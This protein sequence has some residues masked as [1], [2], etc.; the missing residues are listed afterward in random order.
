MK[1]GASAA[2]AA[3]TLGGLAFA[4]DAHANPERYL[5]EVFLMGTSFCPEGSLPADGQMMTILQYQSLYS[6]LGTTYGGDGRVSF[7]LPDLRGRAPIHEGEGPGLN[8]TPLGARGGADT[9]TL[10]EANLPLHSHDV[11]ASSLEA[12]SGAPTNGTFGTSPNADV[13]SRGDEAGMTTLSKNVIG[14]TGQNR[15]FNIRGPYLAMQYCIAVQ[16]YFPPRP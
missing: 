16:G 9:Q 15:P 13:Y 3:L 10:A 8:P 1:I 12:T 5:G 7:A 14:A 2:V 6:L 11:R 4:P